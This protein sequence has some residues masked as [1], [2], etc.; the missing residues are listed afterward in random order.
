MLVSD[1]I[2]C[3]R[4]AH[5][6][7][8]IRGKR[9]TIP[10]FY[11]CFLYLGRILIL[12]NWV[13]GAICLALLSGIDSSKLDSLWTQYRRRDRFVSPQAVWKLSQSIAQE[14]STKRGNCSKSTR[15]TR[16]PHNSLNLLQSIRNRCNSTKSNTK[17]LIALDCRWIIRTCFAMQTSFVAR[18]NFS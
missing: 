17:R 10:V 7:D 11:C 9:Q 8:D 12:S 16:T 4:V 5:M 1:D 6:T 13:L 18:W 3:F 15:I 2:Y 14:T